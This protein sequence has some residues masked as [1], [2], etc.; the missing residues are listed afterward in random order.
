MLKLPPVPWITPSPSNTVSESTHAPASP[1]GSPRPNGMS[2]V[3]AGHEAWSQQDGGEDPHDD[4]DAERGDHRRHGSTDD[5]A[6]AIPTA[7]ANAAAPIGTIPWK[8]Y[9]WPKR[10]SVTLLV[11]SSHATAISEYSAPATTATATATAEAYANQRR[12]V[13]PCVQRK[14]CVPASSSRATNG[15]PTNAPSKRREQHQRHDQDL[16]RVELVAEL[17]DQSRH[18]DSEPLARQVGEPARVVLAVHAA[19]GDQ[20]QQAHTGQAQRDA[21]R[22]EPEAANGDA[23]HQT[24]SRWRTGCCSGSR[25]RW[26]STISSRVGVCTCHAGSITGAETATR[27]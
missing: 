12:R 18:C 24:T 11:M 27:C 6:A 4:E 16:E 22:L 10:S 13:T 20:R 2:S 19:S 21:D 3:L 14:R 26:A 9:S 15:A 5:D 23:Q 7:T 17:L 25:A 8:S 1:S